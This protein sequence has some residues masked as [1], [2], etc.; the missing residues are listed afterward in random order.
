MPVTPST[1][2]SVNHQPSYLS[3]LRREERLETALPARLIFP[4][5]NAADETVPAILIDLSASGCQLLTD[6]RF[7][8]LLTLNSLPRLVVEFFFD[9]M[10]IRQVPIRV[11]WTKKVGNYQMSLGCKFVDLPTAARLALRAEIAK[12]NSGP[13]W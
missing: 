4:R 11:A 8:L 9:E 2:V 6:Q 3:S 12:R 7:S 5:V 13:G 1:P 10:E